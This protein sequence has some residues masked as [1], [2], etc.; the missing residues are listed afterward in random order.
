VKEKITI[1]ISITT[2]TTITT[3][4]STTIVKITESKYQERIKPKLNPKPHLKTSHRTT[5]ALIKVETRIKKDTTIKSTT[6][7]DLRLN[8][9]STTEITIITKRNSIT[10]L[11]TT[12]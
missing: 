9:R 12:L 5:K 1:I 4:T 7:I 2:I 10:V 8:I 6:Q 3:I 11:M